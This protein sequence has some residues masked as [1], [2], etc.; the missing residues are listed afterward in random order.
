MHRNMFRPLLATRAALIIA[1]AAIPLFIPTAGQASLELTPYAG[2]AWWDDET[3]IKDGAHYGGKQGLY[4]GSIGI[5]GNLGFSPADVDTVT[6]NGDN[7]VH[8]LNY[9]GDLVWRL[10]PEAKGVPYLLGG[11]GLTRFG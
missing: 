6:F 3:L 9:S 11:V 10:A 4:F 5:E 7:D 1:L 2:Y 8:I